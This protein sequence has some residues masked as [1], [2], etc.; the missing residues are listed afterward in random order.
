MKLTGHHLCSKLSVD[1]FWSIFTLK[2]RFFLEIYNFLKNIHLQYLKL[3]LNKEN[4]F[5]NIFFI[6]L[7]FFYIFEQIQF[8]GGR[9]FFP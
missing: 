1:R 9:H 5:F 3:D 8:A 7:L 2:I 4:V 6:F